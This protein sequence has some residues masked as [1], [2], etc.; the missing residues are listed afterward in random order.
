ML[1]EPNINPYPVECLMWQAVEHMPSIVLGT[2]TSTFT[3]IHLRSLLIATDWSLIGRCL[4]CKTAA[5]YHIGQSASSS[6][7]IFLS[8]SLKLQVLMTE[9]LFLPPIEKA[10]YLSQLA[11]R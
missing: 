8:V 4:S 6:G 2:L 1:K 3:D 5:V 11:E 9:F 7:F 10:R